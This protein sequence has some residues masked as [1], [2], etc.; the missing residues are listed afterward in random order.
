MAALAEAIA[1]EGAFASLTK[2]WLFNNPASDEAT[3]A[4]EEALEKKK[5]QRI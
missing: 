1:K 5:Q 3:K 4:V 2:V